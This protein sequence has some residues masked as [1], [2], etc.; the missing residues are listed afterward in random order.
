MLWIRFRIQII[1]PDR[2]RHLRYADSDSAD[3]DRY[4]YQSHLGFWIFSKK[5]VKNTQNYD[6]FA[7]DE[8]RKTWETGVAVNKSKNFPPTYFSTLGRIRMWIGIVLMPLRIL[9][10]IGIRTMAIHNTVFIFQVVS[11]PAK[12]TRNCGGEKILDFKIT[13]PIMSET[14]TVLFL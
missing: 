5:F 7:F 8:I 4:Q 12:N 11:I 9:I 2:D 1:F 10:W 6:T 14:S 13:F 3:P